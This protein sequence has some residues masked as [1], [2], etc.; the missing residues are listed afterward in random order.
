MR[1]LPLCLLML[2]AARTVAAAEPLNL[3]FE[4]PEAGQE[5]FRLIDS[6]AD[7]GAVEVRGQTGP[8][9]T[10]IL[11]LDKPQLDSHV[12]VVRG[13]VKY[14]NVLGTA[15][16]EMWNDFGSSGR[17]F[18][19]TLAAFGPMQSLSGSSPWREIELPFTAE[20][21]MRPER[22]T[23]DVV[24]PGPGTIVVG[25]LT[26]S[27]AA[28]S[29]ADVGWWTEQQGGL[30]GGLGGGIL[31]T[32]G[33]VVGFLASRRRLRGV[34]FWLIGAGLVSGAVC[35][36]AGVVALSLHQPFWV[37][38]PLLLLGAISVVVLG[39]NAPGIVRR[40]RDEEFRRM[41]ALDA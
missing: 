21:G 32:L 10:R 36:I 6:G 19:R 14:D 12:Y 39:A 5:R 1:H 17:A 18:T 15:F 16:F 9:S 37:T 2:A 22:L 33:A 4:V 24:M 40:Y 31:G 27:S 13:R 23:I 28:V 11:Q 25:P 38:Y 7:A 8:T 20:P 26:L 41:A 30:V 29:S 35:L 3:K 34:V